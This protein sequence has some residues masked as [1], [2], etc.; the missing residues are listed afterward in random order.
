MN[1]I[2][3]EMSYSDKRTSLSLGGIHYD[4]KKNYKNCPNKEIPFLNRCGKGLAE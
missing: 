2:G 3:T 1:S 4:S